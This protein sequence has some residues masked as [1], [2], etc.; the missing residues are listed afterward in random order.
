V[1]RLLK[2]QKDCNTDSSNSP[3]Q[4][5][6]KQERKKYTQERM[7]RRQEAAM[8]RRK[9]FGSSSSEE[10]DE[11]TIRPRALKPPHIKVQRV[12]FKEESSPFGFASLE[13]QTAMR[14]VRELRESRGLRESSGLL[15]SVRLKD[16][17]SQRR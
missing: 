14:S 9:E 11:I 1:P 13:V 3:A 16:K 4:D 2:E 10:K 6:F 15:S 8:V 7:A 17:H 12:P 5:D